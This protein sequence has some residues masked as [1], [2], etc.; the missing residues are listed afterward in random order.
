VAGRVQR[1][2]ALPEVKVRELGLSCSSDSVLKKRVPA[3][4]E[5]AGQAQ[6][7]LNVLRQA[8]CQLRGDLFV[9]LMDTAGY[10]TA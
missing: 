5:A 4:E 3:E 7:R 8:V 9:E 2:Q 10:W 6:L 1:G